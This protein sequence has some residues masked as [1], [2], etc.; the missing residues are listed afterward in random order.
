MS[1][2]ISVVIADDH[3]MIRLGLAALLKGSDVKIVGEAADGAQA[4]DVAAKLKP[5]VVLVDVLMPKNDGFWALEKLRKKL[6]Q[7]AVVMLSVSENPTHVARAA[8]LGAA[9]YVLKGCS[10]HELVH[11]LHRAVKGGEP[12]ESSIMRRVRLT[13]AKRKDRDDDVPLTN[14]ELQVLRHI[15]MGLSN[16]EIA[17][18]LEISIETVKEHVQNLLHK[19][20]LGDRTQAAV[21]AV[22]NELV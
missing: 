8:S 15:A 12:S 9:D 17:K 7:T 10:K 4:V 18:A 13:M 16:R 11:A 21:W 22:R 1:S 5:D 6:P 20:K 19:L 2:S 3:E 14:R